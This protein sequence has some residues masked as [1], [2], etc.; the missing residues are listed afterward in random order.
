[1]HGSTS[2][3]SAGPDRR[4]SRR[5]GTRRTNCSR[6]ARTCPTCRS[7]TCRSERS[8]SRKTTSRRER[9]AA[10]PAA[11]SDTRSLGGSSTRLRPRKLLRNSE[12]GESLDGE[13]LFR[14]SLSRGDK[15]R[16]A[17]FRIRENRVAAAVECEAFLEH[18]ESL[19][20]RKVAAGERVDPLLERS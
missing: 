3:S 6:C 16:H 14:Q 15:L 5:S 8:R 7:R 11:A 12:R 4:S 1:M 2:N 9:A 20:E 19:V 10:K 18:G 13:R 17:L